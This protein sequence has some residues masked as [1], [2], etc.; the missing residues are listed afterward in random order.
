MEPTI[1]LSKSV[2]TQSPSSTVC[3]LQSNAEM[4]RMIRQLFIF[5]F[6]DIIYKID[7]CLDL[8]FNFIKH[9][10]NKLIV[11]SKFLTYR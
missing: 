2:S 11:N 10:F 9:Q 4:S 8:V 6:N 1:Y 7:I 5:L 3:T